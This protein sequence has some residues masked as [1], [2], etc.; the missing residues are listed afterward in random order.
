MSVGGAR[1]NTHR[2]TQRYLQ[3]KRL[4]SPWRMSHKMRCTQRHLK[5]YS[6]YR[7]ALRSRERHTCRSLLTSLCIC[8]SFNLSLSPAISCLNICSV[9]AFT[10]C[11]SILASA[12]VSVCISVC[13]S[14]CIS[15]SVSPVCISTCMCLS[16]SLCT[17]VSQSLCVLNCVCLCLFVTLCT[18]ACVPLLLSLYLRCSVWVCVSLSL[19][20]H[21]LH[22]SVLVCISTCVL[23][24]YPS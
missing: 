16:V 21:C 8:V 18:Y 20:C 14:S 13:Q 17:S 5:R 24:P 3:R 22:V 2:E 1:I 9:S 4:T 10:C 6:I 12:S 19:L 11:V 7:H 15:L 23:F